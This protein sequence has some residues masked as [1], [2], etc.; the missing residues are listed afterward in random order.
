MSSEHRGAVTPVGLLEA[1]SAAIHSTDAKAV[2]ALFVD[3]DDVVMVGSEE[4]ETAVGREELARLWERVLSRGQ[5]YAWEWLDPR[6][7]TFGDLACV[8]ARAR[9]SIE[10]TAGLGDSAVDYRATMVLLEDGTGW[11]ILSYHGSEPARAW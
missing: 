6:V 11:R 3:S 10:D 5:R 8:F 9:V 1:L 7:S 2:V 4:R